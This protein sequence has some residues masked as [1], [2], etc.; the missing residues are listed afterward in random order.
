MTRAFTLNWKIW[1]D[2]VLDPSSETESPP[3]EKRSYARLQEDLLLTTLGFGLFSTVC[4]AFAYSPLVAG[5]Y[6]LGM[7]GG[8][9][10]LRLLGRGIDQLGKGRDRLGAARWGVFIGLIVLAS[11]LESLQIL[12]IFLGFLSY[13][14]TLLIQ[15]FQFLFRPSRSKRGNP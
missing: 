7:M 5:N 2:P 3:Q 6:F 4:I 14:V 13:K 11:R 8:V 9:V 15:L 10:Y 1:R 12:P